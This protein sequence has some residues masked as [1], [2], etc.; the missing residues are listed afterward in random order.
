MEYAV[1]FKNVVKEYKL[2]KDDKDRFKD[3]FWGKRYTPYRAIDRL[4]LKLPEGEV[5][6]ILG[7]NGSGKSTILKMVTGVVYPT[8]GDILVRGKVSALLELTAGFDGELTGRENIYLKGYSMGMIKNEIS[9]KIDDIIDFSELGEYIEQPVRMYSS[10]MKARLGFAIAVNID[11][12]ILVVDEALAVGDEIFREKCMKRMDKFRDEGKTI[13]FVSHSLP[14][15]RSFCTKGI[16]I[17]EGKLIA[18]GEID[19][20]GN[21]YKHYLNGVSVEKILDDI[22]KYKDL[23]EIKQSLTDINMF[24]DSVE[25]K[26]YVE[27][28]PENKKFT[29]DRLVLKQD[30]IEIKFNI[31][32]VE[33]V[34][35]TNR[36]NYKLNIKLKDIPKGYFNAEIYLN[37][38]DEPFIRQIWCMNKVGQF[39][40]QDYKL[41]LIIKN[42]RLKVKKD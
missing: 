13:L 40:A 35:G 19:E 12:D 25:L 2:Y 32:E 42:N 41:S 8:E 1:E 10:G 36:K 16:W 15:M 24:G 29:I 39:M 14:Q 28:E 7:K 6:G 27:I 22:E 37:I 5:I 20:I 17:H 26:G 33:E 11:P 3:L 31:I 23:V 18:S 9:E 38:D 30:D 4:D 34:S 21:M